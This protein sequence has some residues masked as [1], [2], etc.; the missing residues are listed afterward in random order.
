MVDF[1]ICWY[2][3]AMGAR[4]SLHLEPST[5]I[6][7]LPHPSGLSQ[8]TNFECPAHASILHWSSI[9]H[10]VIH[11]F[12]FP[13]ALTLGL[14][15]WFVLASWT[16]IQNRSLKHVGIGAYLHL[17]LLRTLLSLV[18]V[19]DYEWHGLVIPISLQTVNHWGHWPPVEHE[20]R[21]EQRWY[22]VE[23]K[24][25]IPTESSLHF[26]G[27]WG[28]KP[29]GHLRGSHSRQRKLPA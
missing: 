12:Q 22:H 7:C 15:V 2:I 1:A 10:M 16:I 25:S 29:C 24:W 21:S 18:N 17:L 26:W 28:S 8:T 19:L 6:P 11:M 5:H 9:L 4:V 3:S 13:P 27:R 14:V 23:Q 20:N